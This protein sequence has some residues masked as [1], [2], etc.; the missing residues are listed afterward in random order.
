MGKIKKLLMSALACVGVLGCAAVVG[1]EVDAAVGDKV[2][3]KFVDTGWDSSSTSIS[4]GWTYSKSSGVTSFTVDGA[5]YSIT[6]IAA[7]D[8]L[9]SPNIANNAI[10]STAD[11]SINVG[12]TGTSK[13]LE[14][15][16][17][18]L[19]SGSVVASAS[20]FTPK[21]KKLGSA[22]T[23]SGGTVTVLTLSATSFDSIQVVAGT[24]QINVSEISVTYTLTELSDDEIETEKIAL[25]EKAINEIKTVSYTMD[26]REKISSAKIAIDAVSS[27]SSISNY[28]IYTAAVESYNALKLTAI[29]KFVE[30]VSS[31]SSISVTKN[32]ID[33][34]FGYYDVLLT[35][36]KNSS[37]V[38]SSY[39]DL[40]SKSETY[41]LTNVSSL[42]HSF[43][44]NDLKSGDTYG[45]RQLGNSI[46]TAISNSETDVLTV[47]AQSAKLEG[48]S[49]SNR[50]YTNGASTI[51]SSSLIRAIRVNA[52][53]S[54]KL[55]LVA[56]SQNS[57]D[58][59][60]MVEL[61]N[62]EYT[63]LGSLAAKASSSSTV[64]GCTIEFD[65]EQSGVYY[66]GVTNGVSFY[67]LEFES[68]VKLNY[69]FDNEVEKNAV[70]FIGTINA[71]DLAKV[72]DIKLDLT[73]S[74]GVNSETVTV[75][76]D[77]VYTSITDLD[78]FGEAE[79]VYYIVLELTDLLFARGYTLNATLKVTIDGVEETATIAEA[80]SLALAE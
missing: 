80:I 26:S 16:V 53:S 43:S 8:S 5:T 14:F 74:D 30:S 47:G 44:V 76:F 19:S 50:L 72:S 33:A 69:Q 22:T 54:G 46:F 79:G 64:T 77:T 36:D 62:E 3:Q 31:I 42:K 37:E 6:K 70:R 12:T 40:V 61:Y 25:A 56:L 32:S 13:A 21:D 67:N 29:N 48:I 15:K 1:S 45:Y 4:D 9:T 20:M 73:L 2:E 51:D 10:A 55:K 59:S 18:A 63:K 23:T 35:E 27:T 41:I 66:I 57:S 49:Y 52:P 24:K 34:S 65:I 78:G 17:N 68:E 39:N 71:E 60:R 58:S 28:D 7:G 11:I 38:A 75:A